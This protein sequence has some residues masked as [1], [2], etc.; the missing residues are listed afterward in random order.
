MVYEVKF[1]IVYEKQTQI[2]E[3]QENVVG[4]VRLTPLVAN[5]TSYCLNNIGVERPLS[6]ALAGACAPACCF[7]LY[8]ELFLS[9]VLHL[10]LAPLHPSLLPAWPSIKTFCRLIESK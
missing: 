5:V 1:L 2:I 10:C 7:F 6:R 9:Q 8:G 3:T 4:K